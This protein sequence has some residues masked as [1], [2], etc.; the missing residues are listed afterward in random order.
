M[1]KY[2]P[3]DLT[4]A[5][6]LHRA[7]RE[8]LPRRTRIQ[9]Y[10]AD[11]ETAFRQNPTDPSQAKMLVELQWNADWRAPCAIESA[12]QPFGGKAAQFNYIRD[13]QAMVAIGRTELALLVSHYVDDTWGL[14]PDYAAHLAWALWLELHALV[15]WRLDLGKSPPPTY[16]FRLLGGDLHV[17]EQE[18]YGVLPVDKADKIVETIDNC[19][20]SGRL[21]PAQASSIRGKFQWAR[22]FTWGRWGAAVVAPL[23]ER[24]HSKHTVLTPA[25]VSA[26]NAAK[27]VLRDLGG[28]PMPA[29]LH[30]PQL[31]V[32]VSD[33]E[34]TGSVAV[35]WWQPRNPAWQPRLVQA[36]IP[37]TWRE[38]WAAQAI[39]QIE[40]CGPLLAFRTWKGL[41]NGLWLHFVDNE[42]AKF[43]LIRGSASVLSLSQ[44]THTIWCEA[45]SRRLYVW[46][47][48]VA[49]SDNPVDGASRRDLRDL[50][51]AGWIVQ[52]APRAWTQGLW[53]PS[54]LP[55]GWTMRG[56][57]ALEL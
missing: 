43:A 3:E 40:A 55:R 19:I 38:G 48:R 36:E 44:I 57:G 56:G 29:N 32:T 52:E 13:S 5:W 1:R 27:A 12:G 9:G 25:L 23:A 11:W 15:G 35:G 22:T 2:C 54:L 21:T 47:D 4:H 17:G 53:T 30:D 14:E 31:H 7:L 34:G 50:H 39:T 24:Q 10:R 6:A 33:G 41:R 49:S 26:L 20:H 46:V 45:R 37:E 42:G 28:K 8:S 16:T 51:G 18:P